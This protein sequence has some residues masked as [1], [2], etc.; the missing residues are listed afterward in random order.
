M[1]IYYNKKN[2]IYLISYMSV[3]ILEWIF[4]FILKT[5]YFNLAII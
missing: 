3:S 4:F 5:N 1:S 2:F